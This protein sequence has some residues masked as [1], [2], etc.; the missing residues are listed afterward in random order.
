MS[1]IDII[2]MKEW[3]RSEYAIKQALFNYLISALDT[4]VE[5]PFKELVT[6]F[7]ETNMA[8]LSNLPGDL[9]VFSEECFNLFAD[10]FTNFDWRA[11]YD[12]KGIKY[13]IDDFDDN[14]MVFDTNDVYEFC[15]YEEDD[16]VTISD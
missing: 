15:V 6:E 2:P 11:F 8:E 10:W 9:N 12:S 4:D 5:H 3:K 13:S 14:K 7:V 1:K 16:D